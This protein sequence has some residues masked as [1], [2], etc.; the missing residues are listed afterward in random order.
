MLRSIKTDILGAASGTFSRLR[1]VEQLS[2]LEIS[3]SKPSMLKGKFIGND[4]LIVAYPD[5]NYCL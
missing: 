3:L 4:Q 1:I 5:D 2:S